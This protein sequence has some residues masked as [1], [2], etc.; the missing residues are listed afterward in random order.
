MSIK[1]LQ[2][3]LVIAIQRPHLWLM[4]IALVVCTVVVG[5]WLSFEYGRKVAGYDSAETDAYI[6]SGEWHGKAGGYAIQGRAAIF[7]RSLNGSYSNVVGLPLHEVY[8]LLT[9]RGLWPS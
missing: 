4:T 6:A 2:T 8:S 1:P 7:V 5:F 9:G 3:R